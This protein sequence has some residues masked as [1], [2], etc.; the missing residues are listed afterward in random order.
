MRPPA[1]L[2][3]NVPLT[4]CLDRPTNTEKGKLVVR[5]GRKATRSQ[6]EIARLPVDV[7]EE[8]RVF[9]SVGSVHLPG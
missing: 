3:E 1:P 6:I 5:R 8:H 4:M 7:A 9:V 2:N